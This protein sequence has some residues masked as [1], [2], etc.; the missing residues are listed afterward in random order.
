MITEEGITLGE[1]L[2][3]AV[4]LDGVSPN[5]PMI[6]MAGLGEVLHLLLEFRFSDDVS[7]EFESLQAMHL[8]ICFS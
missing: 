1:S 6:P 5:K 3:I 2:L 7:V 4:Y 8:N